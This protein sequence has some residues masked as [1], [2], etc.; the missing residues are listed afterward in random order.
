MIPTQ[1]PAKL[2]STVLA[3]ASRQ[4]SAMASTAAYDSLVSKMQRKQ[5][6]NPSWAG[7]AAEYAGAVDQQEKPVSVPVP[8]SASGLTRSERKRM[9]RNA[10]NEAKGLSAEEQSPAKARKGKAKPEVAAE[11]AEEAEELPEEVPD[12]EEE[13]EEEEEAAAEGD[14]EEDDAVEHERW[15]SEAYDAHFGVDWDAAGLSKRQ[16]ALQEQR[17]ELPGLGVGRALSSSAEAPSAPAGLDACLRACGVLPAL[18]EAWRR[19][20]GASPLSEA[21]RSLLCCLSGYRDVL[22]TDAAYDAHPSLLRVLALHTMQHITVTQRLIMK[23][24]KKNLQA[25]DQG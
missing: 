24:L 13:E 17:W 14:G 11:E 12:E 6:R 25:R 3:C 1:V 4:P 2:V 16:A 9:R 10:A 23:N 19:A 7:L 22:H 5:K 18:R 21:Q 15:R 8:A 20:H